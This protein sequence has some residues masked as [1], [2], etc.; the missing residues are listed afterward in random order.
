MIA[1]L[2]RYLVTDKARA[3]AAGIGGITAS[4][5]PGPRA[6]GA[7]AVSAICCSADPHDAAQRLRDAWEGRA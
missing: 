3:R 5:P 2:S 1:D 7:A 4:D 6:A